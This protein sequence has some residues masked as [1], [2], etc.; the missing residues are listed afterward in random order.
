MSEAPRL[1]TPLHYLRGLQRGS[2]DGRVGLTVA[3]AAFCQHLSI[4]GDAESPGFVEA[5]R[6]VTPM[7]VFSGRGQ[8]SGCWSLISRPV[9]RLK[10]ICVR[11]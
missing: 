9:T 7:R 1:E 6:S 2:G 5:I 3:E 8:A 4:R 10:V 11:H